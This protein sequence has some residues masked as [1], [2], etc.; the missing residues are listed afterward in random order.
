MITEETIES[1]I[2]AADK[3]GYAIGVDDISRVILARFYED[4]TRITDD[5]VY[6]HKDSTK[7]L[8][9]YVGDTVFNDDEIT[10]EDNRK[11]ILRLIEQT[12]RQRA[13]GEIEA[14]DALKIEADLRVKLNDKF[15]VQDDTRDKVVIVEKKYNMIC[16][17]G[18]EC[19]LPTVDDLKEMYGLVEKDKK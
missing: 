3:E 14:K 8:E 7:W 11:A 18:Y 6:F 15:N 19:Y 2:E 12:Q 5:P 4:R 1:I 9:K 16:R 13:A 10:F 17:H